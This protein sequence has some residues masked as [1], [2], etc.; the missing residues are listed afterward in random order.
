MQ[1]LHSHYTAILPFR[2]PDAI[3]IPSDGRN[4][5]GTCVNGSHV[6]HYGT[7]CRMGVTR[8]ESVVVIGRDL[9][10]ADLSSADLSS[11]DLSSANL[12]GA[13]LTRANLSGADLTGTIKDMQA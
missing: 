8:V 7:L 5:F 4:S 13:N 1:E 11:A 10:N 12:S 3:L 6:K 2:V 9:S